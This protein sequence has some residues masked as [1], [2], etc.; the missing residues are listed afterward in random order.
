MFFFF[1]HSREPLR[2]L[3][4]ERGKEL[5]SAGV[6]CP[7]GREKPPRAGREAGLAHMHR[8]Q[9]IASFGVRKEFSPRTDWQQCLG[10]FRLPLEH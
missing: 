5:G 2:W 9:P 8:E 10:V 6:S 4:V 3:Q 1:C 7:G